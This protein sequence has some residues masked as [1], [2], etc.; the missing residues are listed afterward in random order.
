MSRDTSGD[1]TAPNS[2]WNPAIEGQA[3]GAD[4]WNK[5]LDDIVAALSQSIAANGVT[6][7]TATIPFAY[8]ISVAPGSVGA[9]AVQIT[10]DTTN[11]GIYA[12]GKGQLAFLC[13]GSNV[14]GL[15]AATGLT[16]SQ[17][18]TFSNSL[19]ATAN[20]SL[21]GASGS[22]GFYG[23]AGSTRPTV[24]GAKGGN[25]ALGSLISALAELGLI[26]DATSA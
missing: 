21:A 20:A 19:S 7:T 16:V 4:D 26:A 9:P 11:T 14:L 6:S 13:S 17:A 10:G 12:P 18:A 8:G 1:Y 25:A 15:S 23:S 22:L 2:S 24:S 5:L 3:A